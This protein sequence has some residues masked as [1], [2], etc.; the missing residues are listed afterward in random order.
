MRLRPAGVK[1][2]PAP[3]LHGSAGNGPET[4]GVIDVRPVNRDKTYKYA[5]DPAFSGRG[6]ASIT[7]IACA[8]G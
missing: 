4:L 5:Q 2:K 6:L 7:T 8:H 1:A 3:A